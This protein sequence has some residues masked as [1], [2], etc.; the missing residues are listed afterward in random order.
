MS[1]RADGQV[2][3]RPA[4]RR[5]VHD[6]SSARRL[7]SP[8]TKYSGRKCGWTRTPRPGCTAGEV[9]GLRGLAGAGETSA[10][11]RSAPSSSS[12]RGSWCRSAPR[13]CVTRAVPTE[14]ARTLVPSSRGSGSGV[15]RDEDGRRGSDVRRPDLA[16]RSRREPGRPGAVAADPV[17]VV[18]P[19]VEGRGD[20][21]ARRP[22]GVE[23]VV[24]GAED[25][26]GAAEHRVVAGVARGVDVGLALQVGDV[27][28][29]V[30]QQHDA[31]TPGA[32]FW[33]KAV[34]PM[35][36]IA[37]DGPGATAAPVVLSRAARL[38]PSPPREWPTRR[39]L[40]RSARGAAFTTAGAVAWAASDIDQDCHSA[41]W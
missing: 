12:G 6:T 20:G 22:L 15:A 2:D 23:E 21:D 40:L 13:A 1:E 38:T 25:Q 18:A 31:G 41:R 19:V 30:G 10:R 39:T 32:G 33:P 35:C 14:A 29:A 8:A 9:V 11:C 24:V 16:L 4:G 7:G 17:G 26:D 27:A 3:A 36:T 37:L 34:G 5:P 28:V